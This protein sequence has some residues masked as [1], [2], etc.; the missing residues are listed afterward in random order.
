MQMN[1]HAKEFDDYGTQKI[2]FAEFA[3]IWEDN[4]YDVIIEPAGLYWFEM[5]THWPKTKFIQLCRDVVSWENSL[6]GF[7]Q[8]IFGIPNGTIMDQLLYSNPN[9]SPTAHH[10][11]HK[12]IEPY[13][14]YA[15]GFAPL[16]LN[17]TATYD[18]QE[19]WQQ[20]ISRK[21]RLFHAD[22]TV[23]SPK[24]R[25]LFNYNIKDGWPKLREFLGLPAGD[26]DDFPHENKGASAVNYVTNLW[27]GTDYETKVN[28]ELAEYMKRNGY[29]CKKVRP[30][31]E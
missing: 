11:L 27:S 2:E 20:M 7:M 21:Y 22:I 29:E 10:A 4:H 5:A 14:L 16:F 9:M 25:T 3:K 15:I 28:A 23:N 31:A 26:N 8:T 17:P 19:P 30:K 12:A 18:E 24:E 13:C 6:R 1:D